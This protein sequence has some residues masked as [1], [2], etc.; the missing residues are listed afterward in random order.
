MFSKGGDRVGGDRPLAEP[1]YESVFAGVRVR[2]TLVSPPKGLYI[3]H[4]VTKGVHLVDAPT[5]P[6]PVR[7]FP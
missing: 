3:V 2:H 4:L 7:C 5:P 6:G 1:T